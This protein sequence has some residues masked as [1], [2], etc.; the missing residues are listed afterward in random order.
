MINIKIKLFTHTDLDGV[1][2]AIVGLHSFKDI[3]IEYCNYDDVD[4]KI[5]KFIAEES[6]GYDKVFITDISVSEDV[7]REINEYIGNKTILLDHHATAKWLNKYNWAKVDDYEISPD[8]KVDKQKSSGTSMFYDY[9]WDNHNINLPWLLNFIE[10]VRQYDTWEWTTKF[11]NT[12]PKLLNN[13]YY[14]IGRE[15]FIKRFMDNTITQFTEE[16]MLLL[17][18]EQKRIEKY[19]NKKEKQLIIR[20]FDEYV[21]GIVFAEQYHSEL[22]NE[23]AKRNNV[24]FVII[25]N[26]DDKKVSYRGIKNDIHLGEFAKRYGGG[27]HS[28]AAGSQFKEDILINMINNI[29]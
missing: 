8:P 7:A 20:Q 10:M 28:Q 18:I 14:L 1:G 5:S 2:C 29:F 16:E 6:Y 21:V 26:P 15:R 23:L 19:I 27:G 25:I 22:G 4:Y 3:D 12:H 17:D 11:N 24:D 9:L 13:L